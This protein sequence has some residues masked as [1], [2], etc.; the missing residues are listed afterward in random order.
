MLQISVQFTVPGEVEVERRVRGK[1]C[2]QVACQAPHHN[3]F[4][5]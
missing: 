3:G 4:H 2:Q 5:S 1:V